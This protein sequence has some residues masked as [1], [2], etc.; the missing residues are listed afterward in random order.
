MHPNP[1][2]IDQVAKWVDHRNSGAFFTSLERCSCI[3]I[4]PVDDVNDRIHKGIILG[5]VLDLDHLV[6]LDLRREF[7]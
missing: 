2:K 5:V 3:N 1:A 6:D 4:A 7:G